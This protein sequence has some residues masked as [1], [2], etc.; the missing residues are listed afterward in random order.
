MAEKNQAI[1]DYLATLPDKRQEDVSQLR[2]LILETLPQIREQITYNMPAVAVVDDDIVC[3]YKS[4]KN[5][6]SLYMDVELVEKHKQ[7][8]MGLDCGKSCIRFRR[9]DQLPQDTIKAI[10]RETAA[11]QIA[12]A[13]KK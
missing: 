2:N 13:H 8:L 10:L 9:F 11:K 12:L 5:Y 1:D 6:I 4:Q 3:S 7:E